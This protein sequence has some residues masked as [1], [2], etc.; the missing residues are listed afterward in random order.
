[1]A[2]WQTHLDAAVDESADRM[3][4]LR[5]HLHAHPEPSGQEL[6]TSLHLYRLFDELEL[7]VRPEPRCMACGGKLGEVEK[8]SIRD[9]APT[10]AYAACE[11]FWRCGRCGKLLWRGTHWQ[12]I[13]A[14]LKAAR[15]DRRLRD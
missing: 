3:V 6:Q 11:Q 5:R 8:S 9:E 12:R 10:K 2:S 14:A 1:M 15:P 13:S 7:P 4:A